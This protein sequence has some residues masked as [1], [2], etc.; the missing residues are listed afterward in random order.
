MIPEYHGSSVDAALGGQ[1]FGGIVFCFVGLF[2][3]SCLHVCLVQH[4]KSKIMILLEYPESSLPKGKWFFPA[5]YTPKAFPIFQNAKE[6]NWAI[7]VTHC[8][9]AWILFEA[10]LRSSLINTWVF[11]KLDNEHGKNIQDITWMTL[12]PR[13]QSNDSLRLPNANLYRSVKQARIQLL[14]G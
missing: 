3:L 10:L 14:T 2:F 11:I 1:C 5:S 8:M 7:M 13:S 6:K 4:L 12:K 9:D